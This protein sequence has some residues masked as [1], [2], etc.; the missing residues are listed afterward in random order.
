MKLRKKY[1]L[2][3]TISFLISSLLSCKDDFPVYES[4]APFEVVEGI[5]GELSVS[6]AS[7]NFSKHSVQ[8]RENTQESTEQHIHS[9]Y[10]F[11]VDMNNFQEKGAAECKVLTKKNYFEISGNITEITEGGHKYYVRTIKMPA[12]SCNKAFVFGIINLGHSEVQGVENDAELLQECDKVKTLQDL[13]NLCAKLEGASSD[14]ESEVNVERMQGHHLMSGYYTSL[15]NRHFERASQSYLKLEA[16]KDGSIK[17]YDAISN[18]PLKPMGT[19]TGEGETSALF[20]HRLD[21]KVTV[22]I[23]PDGALKDTQGAYFKLTSWQVINAPYTQHLYWQGA[24]DKIQRKYGNSKVFKRDLTQIENGGWSFSFYQFE[25]FFQAGQSTATGYM[26]IGTK[27]IADQYNREYNGSKGKMIT[28]ERVEEAFFNG[29]QTT[30]PNYISNFSYTMRE[31][32]NKKISKE[33]EQ[34]KIEIPYRP[35][36]DYIP[37]KPGNHDDVIIVDNAGFKYAPKNSTYIRITGEYYNPKEPV[38]RRPDKD[39]QLNE[40]PL[41]E[42]PFLNNEQ[43]P[44]KTEQEAA[45]RMRIATVVYRIHLGY[46]G[47]GNAILKEDNGTQKIK[48]FADFKK[49]LNDYNVLRNHHYTYNIKIAG[50]NNVKLEATRENGG[51][52][53]EQENQ[54]GAEGVVTESQHF[55]ELDSHYETRNFTIDFKRMPEDYKDGFSFGMVSPFDKHRGT[56]KRAANGEMQIVDHEGKALTTIKGRD[57]EWIHFA[58]HGDENNPSRSLIKDNGNGIP[59]SETYGGYEDQQTYKNKEELKKE[60]NGKNQYKLLDVLEFSHLVYNHFKKWIAEGKPEATH[61]MTFTVYVDEYYYDYNPTNGAEVNWTDF[62][63]QNRRKAVFFMEK[64]ETS[65]DQQ[66]WYSDAHLVI[67]QNSIQTMYATSTSRGQLVADVAF[68]IEGL[69]EFRAKYRCNGD[70]FP[71][72][73]DQRKAGHGFVGASKTN[74][75]FNTML[76]FNGG[77][78]L[79]KKI[80]WEEAEKYFNIKAFEEPLK[81]SDYNWSNWGDTSE[82]SNR[83]G[84]WAVYSRNRDLNRNGELDSDEI[85]WFVPAIDQY[86]LCFLGGRPVFR[87]P[88]FERDKAVVLNGSNNSEL[89]WTKGFPVLHYM[90]NTDMNFNRVFWAE[91]GCAKSNYA[92]GL[93]H[94]V[95]GIRMA[96]MLTKAGIVNTGK[97]FDNRPLNDKT[98]WSEIEKI[99]AQDE[100]FIVTTERNGQTIPYNERTDGRNYYVKLNKM[101]VDAFRSI[102]KIGEIGQHH[103]EQKQ[104]WLYKEFCIAKN[105]IGYK[106]P[107]N[108]FDNQPRIWTVNGQ[109]N[110][111]WRINGV[112]TESNI[113][114]GK[115]GV[116]YYIGEENSMA[117]DYYERD[118]SND[119]HH[120]RVP[121]LREAAI[122]SM[123]FPEKWFKSQGNEEYEG[124]I[125]TGT[126]STNLGPRSTKIPY[127]DIRSGT[128]NRMQDDPGD[129]VGEN[130][131]KQYVRGVQ[132]VP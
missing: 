7:D 77:D 67:Y 13:Q 29:E 47:G 2:Y 99:L 118:D 36:E 21:A 86:T 102:I 76:W 14:K 46:V 80:P 66:S 26:E 9:A 129:K 92:Q 60:Q 98:Q 81:Q 50:V 119:K 123:A 122:M 65:A 54:S 97:A 3:S 32:E 101:N 70:K 96:R 31:L 17:A 88:L 127:F 113:P 128:I 40:F 117:Y 85:R 42:Y 6:I 111:W 4:T 82:R 20:A 58:W 75:L 48:D 73:K 78:D 91:E 45:K 51:N 53:L 93:F 57:L 126:K 79:C 12:V 41:D 110:T 49:K 19:T 104:N 71:I 74:G 131:V 116:Y 87:N 112:V 43:K 84:Q 34:E 89:T 103:H 39:K 83:R 95:Y 10:L 114:G 59:Y 121:N 105:K 35:G 16:Q 33:N 5:P 24:E 107:F 130:T 23:T 52:I 108:Q 132:D 69:D 106:Q 8:T 125:T 22:K 124:S 94:G 28:P 37:N 11:M 72:G 100:L 38:R 30:Y 18:K 90:S 115:T 15:N 55:F 63:N 64:E 27:E 1:I 61:T 68:G 62:C 109:P 25:N 56:L 120:W 44:V